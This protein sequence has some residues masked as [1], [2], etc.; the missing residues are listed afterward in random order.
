M[1]RK[2]TIDGFGE[3]IRWINGNGK[4]ED[5]KYLILETFAIFAALK[6]KRAMEKFKTIFLE[7]AMNFLRSVPKQA[8]DK[9]IYNVDKV[10][11]G[12]M[13]KDLF[14]KL[15]GTDIWEFRTLYNGIQ[16]RLFAFWDTEEET[17]VVATHGIIKKFWK[18][19]GKE[20]AKAEKIRKEYFDAK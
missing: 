5:N 4:K 8:K 18:I 2:K 12:I 19:P 7:E 11:G 1:V 17:L 16:Y 13:N 10:S 6:K 3:N 9:I 20:I 14:K 15:D